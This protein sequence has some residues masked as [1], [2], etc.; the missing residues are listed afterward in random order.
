MRI[1]PVDERD[2][3]WEDSD[4]RFR[5]Y[6]FD[7]GDRPGHSWA[8]DTFDVWDA[9]VLEA[10]TWARERAGSQRLFAVALVLEQGDDAAAVTARRRLVWLVGMDAND[11]DASTRGALRRM[12]M[13]RGDAA[14]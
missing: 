10:V 4:P 8:V 5:V 12:L 11:T 7:G 2:S 13:R 1:E 14:N 6:L 9:D 3:S